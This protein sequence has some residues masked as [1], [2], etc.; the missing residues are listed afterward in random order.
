MNRYDVS[1]TGS[2][3]LGMSLSIEALK[4][5]A[6][7]VKKIVLSN[8]A[9][10]NRQ[11]EHLLQLSRQHNIETVYDDKLINK[12]SLKENCYCIAMFDKFY[13]NLNSD[14]HI[15]L[16]QFNS[17]GDLGTIIRSAVSFDFKDIVL[18]DCDIDYF[19]PRC[20][21]SSMGAIFHCNIVKYDSLDSYKK[22]YP[23]YHI[24]PFVSKGNHELSDI[25]IKKPFS[26]LLSQDYY[27][28]DD[29]DGY[30]LK[31]SNFDEISLSIRSSIILE[32]IFSLKS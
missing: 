12:L 22:E 28:L 4:H 19:D 9:N 18:I 30:Y 32:K 25:K 10:K 26:L 16:Y 5:K 31:H 11:L 17:Y 29:M 3:A 8:K 23:D 6:K 1:D 20:I 14:R 2:Y 24:Y 15:L 21:R 7:Y 13:E 27:A